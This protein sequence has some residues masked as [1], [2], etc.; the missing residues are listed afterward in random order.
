M[1]RWL[2]HNWG[3]PFRLNRWL[4]DASLNSWGMASF[5]HIMW[6]NCHLLC[7]WSSS[8]FVALSRYCI[9]SSYQMTEVLLLSLFQRRLGTR[10][11]A[12][13][14][15]LCGSLL[16]ASSLIDDGRLRTLSKCSAHLFLIASLSVR[17]LVP[18]AL[19]RGVV[20]ELW[21][22][23][24]VFSASHQRTSLY[25]FCLQRTRF[26]LT[27]Q[28]GVLHI[29]EPS[30]GCLA[31]IWIC[32]LIGYGTGITKVCLGFFVFLFKKSRDCFVILVK[33]VLVCAVCARYWS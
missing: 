26:H 12:D 30:L 1:P 28:P 5:L 21:R 7:N 27:A 6:N 15:P 22:P 24:T 19:R 14:I 9:W 20:S 10:Q 16:I 2:S 29:S 23:L 8:C 25:P 4:I 31:Y 11:A 3:F 17:R 18:S 33:P 13:Y 32:R